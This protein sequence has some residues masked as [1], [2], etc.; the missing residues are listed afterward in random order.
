MD[1]YVIQGRSFYGKAELW[2]TV[3]YICN[4]TIRN[5][6]VTD[7]PLRSTS[8]QQLTEAIELNAAVSV[9]QV[10]H[11]CYITGQWPRGC[12]QMSSLYDSGIQPITED[13]HLV[14]KDWGES[15]CA[16]RGEWLDEKQSRER[17]FNNRWTQ[18]ATTT[19]TPVLTQIFLS[20]KLT[21]HDSLFQ[22]AHNIYIQNSPRYF[23]AT[24]STTKQYG[25]RRLSSIGVGVQQYEYGIFWCLFAAMVGITMGRVLCERRRRNAEIVL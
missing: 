19:A 6:R 22:R 16:L 2:N 17:G 1:K 25:T 20:Q 9:A 13:L 23:T 7:L 18:Q 8:P 14:G 15:T 5:P 10:L 12:M 11:D 4:S 21:C 3:N 24:D